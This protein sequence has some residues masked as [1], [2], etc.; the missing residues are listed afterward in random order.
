M[1]RQA[2][3]AIVAGLVLIGLGLIGGMELSP[4][5]ISIFL[6]IGGH[7][8]DLLFVSAGCTLV[9]KGRRMGAGPPRITA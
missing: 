2:R 6:H 3:P 4:I 8:I 7:T 5:R 9:A 1:R